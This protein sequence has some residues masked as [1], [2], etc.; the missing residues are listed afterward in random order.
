MA[1]I[2]LQVTAKKKFWLPAFFFALR[3]GVAIGLVREKHCTSIANFITKNGIKISIGK[4]L[5]YP[6]QTLTAKESSDKG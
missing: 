2:T 1:Q 6:G 5:R 4:S 3:A